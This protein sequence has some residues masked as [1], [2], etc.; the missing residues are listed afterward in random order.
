MKTQVLAAIGKICCRRFSDISKV[1]EYLVTLPPL[2]QL[3]G[4]SFKYRNTCFSLGRIQGRGA[5]SE[6]IIKQND[7]TA[8]TIKNLLGVSS[9][10]LLVGSP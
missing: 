2:N 7:Q 9:G 4:K 5:D 10:P 3:Q 1:Y 6:T 8:Y